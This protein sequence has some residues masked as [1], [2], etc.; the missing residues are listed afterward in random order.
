MIN[1]YLGIDVGGT[2]IKYAILDDNDNILDS[3]SVN[4]PHDRNE[5]IDTLSKIINEFKDIKGVGISMP[6]FIDSDTG[7][8]KTAGALANL[9]E[10]NLIELLNNKGIS[11]P[12][13]VENDAKCAAISEMANGNAKGV[14]NFVCITIGTGIGGGIVVNG[15]LVKGNNLV[16]GELGIM[17]NDINTNV[18]GSEVGAIMPSRI[19]YAKKYNLDIEDVDGKL[20]LSDNEISSD[21]YKEITRIIFNLTFVLN[22]EKFLIG[23]AISQDDK[24]ISKLREICYKEAKEINESI[25]YTI[26]R[27][28]NT[29]NA[30]VIG[31]VFELKKT[32]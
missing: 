14:D 5:F 16:A 24:F 8:M 25:E 12:I 20:A 22:P 10:Y 6:G 19:K 29:N 11:I 28:K 4:T 1:K 15:N 17:R 32:F 26:D 18:T 31:A 3:K 7:Y 9:Y 13:H 23:G 2:A 21:F 30:G 27:C